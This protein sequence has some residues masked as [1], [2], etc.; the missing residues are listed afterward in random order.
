MLYFAY[1]GS[2]NGDWVSH[3]AIRLACHDTDR[4]L[5]LIHVDDGEMPR[6]ELA[7]K[8]GRIES[9]CQGRSVDLSVRIAPLR[10]SVFASLVELLPPGRETHLICGTRVRP[11]RRGYLAGTVSESLLR[12]GRFQVLAVRVVQPGLLGLP[13]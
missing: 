5:E 12:S 4:R 9:E 10:V 3:Y 7:K 1:D 6:E 8:L 11:R 2:I 13:K